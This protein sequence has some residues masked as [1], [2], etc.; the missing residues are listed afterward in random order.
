MSEQ[1]SEYQL[2]QTDEYVNHLADVQETNPVTASED[3]FNDFGVLLLKK[4]AVI[5]PRVAGHLV[6]HKLKKELDQSI[7][8]ANALTLYD[9]LNQILELVESESE[10]NLLHQHFDFEVT[11]RQLFF[12]KPIPAQVLQRLTVMQQVMPDIYKRSLFGAWM[13]PLLAK[14]MGLPHQSYF[15]AFAAGLS[16]DIGLLHIPVDAATK[17]EGLSYSQWRALKSH[18]I[19]ARIILEGRKVYDDD[20]LKG[21]ADHQER[22]DR[23]GYPSYKPSKEI[24]WVAPLVAISDQLFDIFYDNSRDSKT[25]LAWNAYLEVNM[26]TFGVRNVEPLLALLKDPKIIAH[27]QKELPP[28][29]VNDVAIQNGQVSQLFELVV[30]LFDIAAS[31][32]RSRVARAVSE[33]ITQLRW[34]R[35]SAGMGSDHLSE[36]LEWC[37]KNPNEIDAVELAEISELLSCLRW[38]FR[39]LWRVAVE[40]SWSDKVSDEDKSQVKTIYQ[41]MTPLLPKPGVI[42]PEA[43]EPEDQSPA[44]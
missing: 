11:L 43:P 31:H 37:K 19:V 22:C 25:I 21:V 36:W 30:D 40:F 26:T 17:Q 1:N 2:N 29:N 24:G 39:H 6:Q 16:H 27:V 35:D 23:S 34:V 7:N 13:A 15:S 33:C 18:P 4:G 38:R 10:F 12:A 44:M 9:V 32:P 42:D 28:V 14:M 20:T 41:K 8:V 3:I 5:N